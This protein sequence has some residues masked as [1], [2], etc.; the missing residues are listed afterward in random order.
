[1]LSV[2]QFEAE[3]EAPRDYDL[4]LLAPSPERPDPCAAFEGR[5]G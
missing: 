5:G 1:V 4:V 3:P 2:G